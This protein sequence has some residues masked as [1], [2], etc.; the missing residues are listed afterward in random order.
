[1]ENSLRASPRFASTTSSDCNLSNIN[2]TLTHICI[3]IH[4]LN[5]SRYCFSSTRRGKNNTPLSLFALLKILL[6]LFCV[7]NSS[8]ENKVKKTFRKNTKVSLKIS[9]LFTQ[10]NVKHFSWFS[11]LSFILS[12]QVMI[13]T[14]NSCETSLSFSSDQRSAPVNS[15]AN[16]LV[17]I[18]VSF[19]L[20]FNFA[21]LGRKLFIHSFGET[22]LCSL[23][24][25]TQNMI[26][27]RWNKH[28]NPSLRKRKWIF[29]IW[30]VF[31]VFVSW[32]FQW[33]SFITFYCGLYNDRLQWR[34]QLYSAFS[35]HQSVW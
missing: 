25:W 24:K 16:F 20:F 27:S 11:L 8:R 34:P 1:M 12:L 2:S 22:N 23:L 35:A 15:Y 28:D 5:K 6:F 30:R 7:R 9:T 3:S 13:T 29:N 26:I 18:V 32:W 14:R 19:L 31:F 21:F 10:V 33:K 17:Q 4:D